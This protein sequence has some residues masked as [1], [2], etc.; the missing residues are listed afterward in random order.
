[1]KGSSKFS[2][3]LMQDGDEVKQEKVLKLLDEYVLHVDRGRTVVQTEQSLDLLDQYVMHVER[4]AHVDLEAGRSRQWDVRHQAGVHDRGS[5]NAVLQNSKA[6][7]RQ[8]SE[9][10]LTQNIKRERGGGDKW[11]TFRAIDRVRRNI[12]GIQNDNKS[13]IKPENHLH[14]K[15]GIRAKRSQR[16]GGMVEG[17]T[18]SHKRRQKDRE[19]NKADDIE[20]KSGQWYRSSIDDGKRIQEELTKEHARQRRNT[21][22]GNKTADWGEESSRDLFTG[23]WTHTVQ[24]GDA[25]HLSW[26]V[27]EG[28]DEIEF[29][30]EAATRGYVGVGFSP[31]GGMAAAD[32]VLAWVDDNTAQVYLVVSSL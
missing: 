20:R 25:V 21:E 5:R 29:L 19:E 14:S 8:G 31:G 16:E 2:K 9:R 27:V 4:G 30:V 17:S 10:N 3:E 26:S 24:L 13:L 28:E 6:L 11:G 12:R 23:P 32:I 1:M 22:A 7:T 18:F 15:H